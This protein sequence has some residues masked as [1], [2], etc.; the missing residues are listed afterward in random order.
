M[1]RQNYRATF[2]LDKAADTFLD[3][4]TWGKGMVWVNGKAI[5]RFWKIG[6]QQ[7]LYMP[8]CWLK[9]GENEIIVLDLLGP[10][11]P[12][13]QGLEQ[14]ILDELHA[15]APA[16]HRAE[17][18]NLDLKGET[19]VA[20]G[21]L[22]AADGWQEVMFGRTVKGRYVCLEATDA[23][24]GKDYA[25]LAELYV[26]DAQGKP[27]PRLKWKI[28]YADSESTSWGNYTADKIYD[29][30]ESTYWGTRDKDRFPHQ[31]VI[32]L[33]EEQEISGLRLLPRAEEGRP[34]MIK[35]YKVYVKSSPFRF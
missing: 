13:I 17:G 35:G 4:R 26:L 21:Q 9:E 24:D 31:I 28:A 29:L 14:P 12:V 7:T 32:D 34:G 16:T 11:Q 27:L 19:P 8:G 18:Q 10:D 23:Q 20:R 22:K 5:G 2:R 1:L 30:Q 3:M 25:A 33:G 6:P 15:E